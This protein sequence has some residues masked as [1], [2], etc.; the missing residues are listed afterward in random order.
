MCVYIVGLHQ[1]Q[2]DGDIGSR[3]PVKPY[4]NYTIKLFHW[5]GVSDI[6]Q[7]KLII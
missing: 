6:L 7:E 1:D 3:T 4:E 5:I 2:Y